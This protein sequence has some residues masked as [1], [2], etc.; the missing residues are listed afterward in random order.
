MSDKQVRKNK[1]GI[2]P[3]DIPKREK[4]ISIRVFDE[5]KKA[6]LE[7]C[8][9]SELA[10]WMRETCLEKKK[11]RRPNYP[12]IDP[13]LLRQLSSIGNNLNQIARVVNQ[14]QYRASDAVSIVSALQSMAQNLEHLKEQNKVVK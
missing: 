5:E 3:R 1:D 13:F 10:T 7:R 2:I 4:K 12:T 8:D 9:G 14:G 11:I 6:L